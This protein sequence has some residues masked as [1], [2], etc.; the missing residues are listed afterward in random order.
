MT[1]TRQGNEDSVGTGRFQFPDPPRS[2]S[3]LVTR[4]LRPVRNLWSLFAG[5]LL[6]GACTSSTHDS[7]ILESPRE[8]YEVSAAPESLISTESGIIGDISDILIGPKG[9][10]FLSD[11]QASAVHYVVPGQ[12][13]IDG[14]GR[15]GAGPGELRLPGSMAFLGDTLG[16]VD[17]Q[18]G[19]VQFF[20]SD[21]AA[22]GSRPL[23]SGISPILGPTLSPSGD[24]I[25]ATLGRD[26]AVAVIYSADGQEKARLGK[27]SGDLWTT[28]D[29]RELRKEV[30]EGRLPGI[31]ANMALPVPDRDGTTWL[32]LQA[33]GIIER[34]DRNGEEILSATLSEPSFDRIREEFVDRNRNADPEFPGL[35]ALRFIIDAQAL[36]PGLWMLVTENDASPTTILVLSNDGIVVREYRFPS[37]TGAT[38]F[39]VDVERGWAYF[40]IKES[41]ELVRVPVPPR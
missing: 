11:P 41:A 5:F 18:N 19:R 8:E 3:I 23:P 17:Q 20:S 22:V 39:A 33:K 12:G 24:L 7:S 34:F 16:V 6:L 25:V 21:G 40:G 28:V 38:R 31:L 1:E 27:S 29:E 36:G 32:V 37:V 14:F 35:F 26:T 30:T 10:V 2:E 4:K 15:A 9:S 13:R